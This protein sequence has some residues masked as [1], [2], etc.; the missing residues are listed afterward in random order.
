MF[1]LFFTIKTLDFLNSTKEPL[2]VIKSHRLFGEMAT[3]F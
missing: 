1:R 2:C 3:V